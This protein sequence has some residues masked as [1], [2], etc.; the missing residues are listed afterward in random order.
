[1]RPTAA[2]AS[3]THDKPAETRSSPPRT[4]SATKSATAPKT[5]GT[6]RPAAKSGSV[7]KPVNPTKVSEEKPVEQ[8]AKAEIQKPQE[9]TPEVAA[10]TD[11]KTEESAPTNGK[12]E[13]TEMPD[14]PIPATENGS[15]TPQHNTEES[16]PASAALES[17]PAFGQDEIR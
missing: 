13:E 16:E 10:Y 2:S 6:T 4:K 3:K 7:S 12:V 15:A 1:M 5:N 11:K 14:I 17:T 8:A 9:Q